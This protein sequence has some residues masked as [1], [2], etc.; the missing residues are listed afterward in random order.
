VQTR[1]VGRVADRG[2]VDRLRPREQQPGMVVDR[3]A[4]LLRE[5][6]AQ[7]REARLERP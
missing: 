1:D 7:V 3:A 5:R 2:E 6:Q 4:R